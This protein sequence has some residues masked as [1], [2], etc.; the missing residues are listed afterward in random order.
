MRNIVKGE[1][2][3]SE[4][5]TN[6]SEKLIRKGSF[7]CASQLA[8]KLKLLFIV[9]AICTVTVLI[10]FAIPLGEDINALFGTL[11]VV[12]LVMT[13]LLGIAWAVLG[14]DRIYEYEA[15]ETEFVVKDKDGA[16]EIFYYSDVRDIEYIPMR[17]GKNRSG[18]IVNIVTGI[19]TVSYRCA[20]S[21]N[22]FFLDPEG[23]PFHYLAV[24]CGLAQP[25]EKR[26]VNPD[27][28][29]E[30]FESMQRAQ[31]R[32]KGVKSVEQFMDMYVGDEKKK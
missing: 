29:M 11:T 32:K 7:N 15:L 8:E 1:K 19:K 20:F 21:D 13:V 4:Q 24:N 31:S 25:E 14:A 18:Y 2:I 16:E 10:I 23:T 6:T 22:K 17:Y 9:G 3:M 26:Q 12:C 30:Q 5:N 27:A 28:I